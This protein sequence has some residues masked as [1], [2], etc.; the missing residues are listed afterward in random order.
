M[1]IR[2]IPH[3]TMLSVRCRANRVQKIFL[4]PASCR[5]TE[6]ARRLRDMGFIFFTSSRLPRSPDRQMIKDL[7][8]TATNGSRRRGSA[9][10]PRGFLLGLLYPLESRV[11][12]YTKGSVPWSDLV[13][14]VVQLV[15]VCTAEEPCHT[16]ATNQLLLITAFREPRLSVRQ[17]TLYLRGEETHQE[18]RGSFQMLIR[19][20]L[21]LQI[22]GLLHLERDGAKRVRREVQI[23][24]VGSLVNQPDTL[25]PGGLPR[26][27]TL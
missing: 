26:E 15:M 1:N 21:E 14:S 19:L 17:Q 27:N 5:A 8:L 18:R 22:R 2:P 24:G 20:P 10:D 12:G 16:R 4:I 3:G 13:D 25:K 9:V 11:S 6:Q 23:A 7:I